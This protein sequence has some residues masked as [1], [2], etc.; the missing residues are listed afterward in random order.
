MGTGAGDESFARLARID[1]YIEQLFAAEDE[2]LRAART[3]MAEAGL[4]AINVSPTAGK[5]LYLLARLVGAR[6]VLEIG[7]LGGYSAIWLARALPDDGRLVTLELE[8]RHAAIARANLVRAGVA[9]RVEIRLGPALATLADMAANG[10][11]PFDLVF[12][13]ADKPPYL[14]YLEWS[15]RLS[16]PGT[17][18]VADNVVQRGAVVEP[19]GGSVAVQAIRRF[20]QALAADPRLEALILP[21]AR[22]EI[23]GLALARVRDES[24]EC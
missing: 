11:G 21:M 4:P 13:D 14:D 3:A 12:I 22:Q 15:L 1:G 18:I 10:E 5:L 19:D 16:R 6:R 9:E 20:N 2:A 23:D 24:A 7:T 8:E 17:L